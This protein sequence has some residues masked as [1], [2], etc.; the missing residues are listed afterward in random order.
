LPHP[1]GSRSRDNVN[2]EGCSK[3]ST[4]RSKAA[5]FWTRRRSFRI[6][7]AE[8]RLREFRHTQTDNDRR[9]R[10]EA[11]ARGRAKDAEILGDGHVPGALDEIPKPV[12]VALRGRAV[13]GM[14]T[15]IGRLLTPLNS[16]R[17]LQAVR[18]CEMVRHRDE[19]SRR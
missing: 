6:S 15:F 12:V 14:G 7:G 5:S 17:T 16:S 9:H 3:A 18:R 10:A 8:F 1:S 4:R 19:N 13:V 11:S 2:P